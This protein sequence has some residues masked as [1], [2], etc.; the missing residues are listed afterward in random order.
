MGN[1]LDERNLIFVQCC[2]DDVEYVEDDN[3]AV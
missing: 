3:F 2:R 1:D